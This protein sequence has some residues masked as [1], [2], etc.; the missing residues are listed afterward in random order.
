MQ[1]LKDAFINTCVGILTAAS[2]GTFVTLYDM[3]D[4]ITAAQGDILRLQK[5]F[6][7]IEVDLADV[8]RGLDANTIEIV[9]VR[10]QCERWMSS[11]RGG[12]DGR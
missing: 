12:E 3:R 2:V 7:R 6:S 8:K 11:R 9:R 4:S 1:T 10:A 5:D